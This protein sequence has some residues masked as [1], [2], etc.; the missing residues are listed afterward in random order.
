MTG[1]KATFTPDITP[2]IQ[3][4]HVDNYEILKLLLDRGAAL[5]APHDVRCGCD[6]CLSAISSDSLK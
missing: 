2:L 3:A 4:S 5:P 1:V 6:E